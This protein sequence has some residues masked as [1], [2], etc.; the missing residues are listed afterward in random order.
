MRHTEKQ[1]GKAGIM[2]EVLY[3]ST[4]GTEKGITASSAILK[5]LSSGRRAVCAGSDSKA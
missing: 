2:V 3:K 5:G 4:R 1:K